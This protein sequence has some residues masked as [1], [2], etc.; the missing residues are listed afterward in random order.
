M[1]IIVLGCAQSAMGAGWWC[2]EDRPL[3]VY[4]DGV[5]SGAAY[6]HFYNYGDGRSMSTAYYKDLRPG[7]EDVRVETDFYW[8][9]TDTD[10]GDGRTC[11]WHDVSKQTDRYD[12]KRWRKHARAR[13][14]D[15]RSSRSRGLMDICEIH[16][17]GN[18]PCS[19]QMVE[20]FDY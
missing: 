20:T 13:Y 10:C 15:G 6:G 8:W 12:G 17:W 16:S 5:A 2:S 1:L 4:D 9:G 3:K 19:P 7:G 14:L 11:F 18:D